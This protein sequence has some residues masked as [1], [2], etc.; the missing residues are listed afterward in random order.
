M[1]TAHWTEPGSHA[2]YEHLLLPPFVG[3]VCEVHGIVRI[4]PFKIVLIY[5][6]DCALRLLRRGGTYPAP[7]A[8]FLKTSTEVSQKE[9]QAAILFQTCLRER[10]RIEGLLEVVY[11]LVVGYL[12]DFIVLCVWAFL[13]GL[14]DRL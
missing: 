9:W 1:E 2:P 6:L 11:I 12:N 13:P 4:A 10:E 8:S 14:L 3:T 5:D 7:V